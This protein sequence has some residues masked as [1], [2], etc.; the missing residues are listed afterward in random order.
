MF[1]QI[2]DLPPAK[3][4]RCLLVDEFQ[5]FSTLD[6]RLL[7]WVPPRDA[8][9][10]LFLAGDPVQKILVKRL[11]LRDAG[12]A[13]GSAVYRRIKKNYRNSR[14]I[15]RAAS[16]L[17][18]VYGELARN[19]G[20]DIE[21]LDP[22][23]AVRE[24][25]K[26][27]ALKTD[28]QV[29]KAWEVARQC[30]AEGQTQAWTICIATA[31][32]H[33]YSTGAVLALRPPGLQ[34]EVLSGDYIKRPDTVVVSTLNDLKGFEFNL[35]LIVGCDEGVCPAGDVAEGEVWRDALRFYVCMTRARDQVYMLYEGAP[36]PF[37][38]QMED[39]IV[40]T[41]E[42]LK[43]DYQPAPAAPAAPPTAQ[44]M[45]F[46]QVLARKGLRPHDS[47]VEHLSGDSLALLR[48]FYNANVDKSKWQ[49]CRGYNAK[50]L[51]ELE[52]QKT[53]AFHRWVNPSNL[54]RLRASRF[55]PWR[56]ID[57]TILLRLDEELRNLGVTAFLR[58][59]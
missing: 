44:R 50:A 25:A 22:E 31:S 43:Q 19:S 58:E 12:L 17:A 21:V 10:G 57:R 3:R 4:F 29:K 28:N 23:L 27:I 1:R 40:W 59:T 2:R 42:A 34:A 47:C 55:S 9:N 26:P 6:L 5:D 32:T 13:E 51:E 49:D 36:S 30:L 53:E 38:R 24:T 41:E 8:E 39:R 7:M 11:S 48:L 20:E 15:L 46:T 54:S 33:K 45:K 52:R 37:L 35:V 18:N 14:Q 16:K 56:N